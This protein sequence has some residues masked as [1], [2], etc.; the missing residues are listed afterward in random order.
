MRNE[1][2]SSQAM[3]L[4]RI[5][6]VA[7][8][9]IGVFALW[10]SPALGDVTVTSYK[11]TSNLPAFAPDA[12]RIP[13]N[14]P[15]TVVSG[16]NPNAGSYTTFTYS[17]DTDDVETALTNF[18]PGLL[19]NPESVPKCPQAALEAGGAACP[20]GS[21]IGTSRLDVAVAAGG[22]SPVAG[23]TGSLYNAELL[24]S[25]PGRLAAVTNV[26]G[27]I[28]VSSIPFTITPRPGGDYGLT[29]TLS[30]ISQLDVSCVRR[31]PGRGPLFHHQRLHQQL[32]PQPDVV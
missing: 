15:S 7:I 4:T 29:G 28:L 11:I 1:P 30:E 32:R 21:Q 3:R 17:N 20:A 16:A 22:P 9:A 27:A 31:P 5:A 25:E 24:G 19:G 10:A 23:F 26:A 6:V 2:T 12:T 18:G 13:A 14:G 8:A